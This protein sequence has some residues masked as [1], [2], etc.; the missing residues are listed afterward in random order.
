MITRPVLAELQALL[1]LIPKFAMRFEPQ[2]VKPSPHFV[3]KIHKE[4]V[5]ISYHSDVTSSKVTWHKAAGGTCADSI[6]L[7]FAPSFVCRRRNCLYK[8]FF[9]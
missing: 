1:S 3:R 5:K 6:R 7:T 2:A 9:L 4:I 8:V